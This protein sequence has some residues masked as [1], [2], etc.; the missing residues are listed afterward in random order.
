MKYLI[1]VIG[2]IATFIS[3]TVIYYFLYFFSIG[4]LVGS[5]RKIIIRKKF[6][7]FYI[8]L[9]LS[10]IIVL[11]SLESYITNIINDKITY[12]LPVKLAQLNSIITAL[13][14][15]LMFGYGLG[16]K[17]ITGSLTIEVAVV[18]VLITTGVYG[19]LVYNYMFFYWI[20]VSVRDVYNFSST[21]ILV[22]FM[23]Y[24]LLSS[25]SNPF[26]LGGFSG[27]Y[28]VPLLI[29]NYFFIKQKLD[30]NRDENYN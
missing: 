3:N 8:I 9:V 16:Y 20:F 1:Y 6:I 18:H 29:A 24:V 23:I 26:I 27:F 17:Y 30:K 25:L 22:L 21:K 14:N 5:Y 28:V 13:K 7:S 2:G 11:L 12:S 4:I 19:F 15:D 10:F